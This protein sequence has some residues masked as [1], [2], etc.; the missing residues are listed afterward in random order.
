M[1]KILLQPVRSE[2]QYQGRF[3]NFIFGLLTSPAPLYQNLLKHTGKYGA[4]LHGITYVAPPLADANVSCFLPEFSANIQIRL[5]RLEIN[6]LRFHEVGGELAQQILLESW[7]ALQEVDASI[8]VAEHAVGITVY[9]QIQEASYDQLI[10]RYVM[11]PQGLG[12]NLHAG[13]V[14]YLPGD[15]ARGE[16]PGGIVL[17]RLIGQEQGILLKVTASF[18]A[19]Q[20]SFNTLTQSI[21]DYLTGYLDHLGLVL[22]R[23]R[24][25]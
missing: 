5:D 21:E 14:F 9:T 10:E 23:G 22:D 8:L 15:S 25:G 12:G 3:E 11:I 7:A 20:V 18:D 2:V 19:A 17:D 4:T 13:V 6:F 24:G 1:D 16:R